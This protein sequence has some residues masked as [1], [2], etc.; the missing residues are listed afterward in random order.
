MRR[1]NDNFWLA[2]RGKVL[3]VGIL[4]LTVLA[5]YG[6]TIARA[7]DGGPNPTPTHEK[8]CEPKCKTVAAETHAKTV[9]VEVPKEINVLT[10]KIATLLKKVV[11]FLNGRPTAE[12][13]G[14][15]EAKFYKACCCPKSCDAPVNAYEYGGSVVV[16]IGAGVRDG[17]S[18][19]VGYSH[20]GTPR[21]S[22]HARLILGP[23]IKV[24]N[25]AK[26]GISGEKIGTAADAAR[27]C[28]DGPSE[29]GSCLVF[30]GS[31]GLTVNLSLKIEVSGRVRLFQT[32]HW[33]T[34][35]LHSKIGADAEG[36]APGSV[37]LKYYAGNKCHKH[38][39][40]NVTA[41]FGPL[42]A[43]IALAFDAF[44]Y[45]LKPSFEYEITGKHTYP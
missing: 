13:S 25:V 32:G 5:F 12:I 39:F 38:G 18:K 26:V 37:S 6:G 43:G 14:E 16:K 11:P 41:S 29:C 33:Y 28:A 17:F 23:G 30:T 34:V 8:K 3:A 27:K 35:N 44:G 36:T 2:G 7:S 4:A 9:K 45:N 40:Q 10:D 15:V 1:N 42:T 21:F 31:D 24:L 22:V 20:N 19:S